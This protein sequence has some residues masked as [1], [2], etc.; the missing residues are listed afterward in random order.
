M[1][2]FIFSSLSKCKST[3]Y[4][5]LLAASIVSGQ[6][7]PDNL[8]LSSGSEIVVDVLPGNDIIYSHPFKKGISIY[9]LAEVFH[10]KADN[11]FA[12]NKL[13]PAQ[14][15]NEGKIVKIPLNKDYLIFEKV[16]LNKLLKYLPI[17]YKVNKSET[18]YRISK[19]YLGIETST[20]LLLNNKNSNDLRVGEMLLIGWW[21]VPDKNLKRNQTVNNTLSPLIMPSLKNEDVGETVKAD[22]LKN[23]NSIPIVKYY[24]SDVVGWWDKNASGSKSYYVLHDEARP[25]ST[26]DIYNPMFRNHIKAKVI[27]KIPQDTYGQDIGIIISPAIARDLG[28]LDIRYMVNIKYEK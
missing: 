25:G 9:N 16:K 11:L 3:I 28:I 27:G 19:Q 24:L 12:F 10:L 14:P 5:F 4:L 2:Q 6:N 13:N 7:N 1:N 8:F 21:A 23:I 17:F 22:S 15:I 20:L 18:I 26:M